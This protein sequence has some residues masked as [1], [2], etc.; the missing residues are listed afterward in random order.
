MLSELICWTVSPLNLV[1]NTHELLIL[2]PQ[3]TA[4]AF[5]FV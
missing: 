1:L 4:I 5:L 2:P 3:V